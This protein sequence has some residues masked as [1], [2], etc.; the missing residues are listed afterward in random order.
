MNG[1]IV[2]NN[3]EF[4]CGIYV[5]TESIPA[6]SMK[7]YT[8]TFNRIFTQQ[9]AVVA[10][11]LGTYNPVTEVSPCNVSYIGADRFLVRIYNN[12]SSALTPK[13]CWIASL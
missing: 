6:G 12:Y 11:V 3:R 9:P 1:T 10:S 5:P 8:I 7:E 2:N 13:V 4:D